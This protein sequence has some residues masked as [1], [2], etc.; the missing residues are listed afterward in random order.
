M[1]LGEGYFWGRRAGGWSRVG[2][3]RGKEQVLSGE[4][5]SAAA[6]DLPGGEGRGEEGPV[7][8]LP[9]LGL[10]LF[11]P[12]LSPE[13]PA[14]HNLTLQAGGVCLQPVPEQREPQP[15]GIRHPRHH[16]P[17][18]HRSV[19]S[20]GWYAQG[21][22]Q[23]AGCGLA[24]VPGVLACFH[25]SPAE[26]GHLF[27]PRQRPVFSSSPYSCGCRGSESS[28]IGQRGWGCVIPKLKLFALTSHPS[29]SPTR[30][31][32]SQRP[33][34]SVR[35]GKSVTGGWNSSGASWGNPE[36]TF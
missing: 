32:L 10:A 4:W 22:R 13:Q 1:G 36:A 6:L 35:G 2:G 7:S 9:R 34:C 25:S 11:T 19:A 18:S 31:P 20:C 28:G 17:E 8:G 27:I 24:C 3:S 30:A 33:P 12:S 14:I 21:G 26:V 23:G 15:G 29:L 16:E 5:E